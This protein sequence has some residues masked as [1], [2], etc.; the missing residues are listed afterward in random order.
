MGDQARYKSGYLLRR[1]ASAHS[2]LDNPT[3]TT[4]QRRGA[5]CRINHTMNILRRLPPIPMMKRGLASS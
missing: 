1:L 2:V 4:A 3:A 5:R